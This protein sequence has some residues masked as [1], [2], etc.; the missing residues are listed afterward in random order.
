M[1]TD[2][3]DTNYIFN[4][5]I[6]KIWRFLLLAYGIML[7]YFT[8]Y[9]GFDR[10]HE[11]E[12]IVS[13]LSKFFMISGMTIFFANMFWSLRIGKISI[14]NN[15]LIIKQNESEKIIELNK[16]DKITFGKERRNFYYLKVA[17][18][19]LI[20][21]LNKSQIAKLK[22]ILSE[23]N[24][25]I[26]HRHFTDRISE[27]FNKKNTLYNNGVGSSFYSGTFRSK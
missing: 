24:V 16:I 20:I 15:E 27:W 25:R 7:I 21:E 11:F 1:K 13:V 3:I 6:V 23:L 26:K 17:E 18:S 2:I 19:D 4:H 9:S 5:R 22:T 14:K 10:L 12:F 8:T